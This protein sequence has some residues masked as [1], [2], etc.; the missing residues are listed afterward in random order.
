M[1]TLYTY[2][3]LLQHLLLFTVVGFCSYSAYGQ[4]LSG[5]ERGARPVAG[6]VSVTPGPEIVSYDWQKRWITSESSCTKNSQEGYEATLW[7]SN[8]G[9]ESYTV[10]NLSVQDDP[11]GIFQIV[12]PGNVQPGAEI[13]PGVKEEFRVLFKPT[14]EKYY[15]SRIRLTFSTHGSIDSVDG[16]LD[17]VGV[18]AYVKIDDAEFIVSPSDNPQQARKL[19]EIRST[20]TAPLIISNITLTGN[21]FADF[22]FVGGLPALP[23]AIP[24]GGKYTLEISFNL[25]GSTTSERRAQLNVQG[26]FAYVDCAGSLS[27]SSAELIGRIGTLSVSG[28]ETVAGYG[29]RSVR[30]NPFSRE[31]QIDFLLAHEGETTVELYNG[32]GQV[33]AQL[34][35]EWRQRGLH[36]L[37]WDAGSLTTGLY[38]VQVTANGWSEARSILLVR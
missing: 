35:R 28:E 15:S 24:A 8:Q 25:S 1:A 37:S 9:D 27:D 20:G 21:D 17:G 22:A 19:V 26:N 2:N 5:G 36:L 7:I 33:V 10:E 34:L 30:S 4:E 16:A 32:S 12:D 6:S 29:V 31:V 3:S 14:E 13:K 11:D 38:F 18:E 23:F